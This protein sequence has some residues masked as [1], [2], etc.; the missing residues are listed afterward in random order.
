MNRFTAGN[1]RDAAAQRRRVLSRADSTRSRAPSARSGSRRTSSPT[2]RPGARSPMRWSRAAQRGVSVRVLVD[3]WG[4]RHYLTRPL[5]QRLVDGGVDLLKYRP[6][7]HAVAFPL[8]PAAPAASQAVP[9]RRARR[10]RRRHQRH[11]RHEHAGPHAAARRLRRARARSDARADHPDDAARVGDRRDRAAAQLRR[12]AVSRRGARGERR[13][14][15]RRSSR[16]ATTCAIGATSSAPISPAM[17][18]ARREILIATA[19]FFPGRALSP[20]ADQRGRA[21]RARD[22]AAAGARRVPAAALCVAR[23]VRPAAD[24]R[25]RDPGISSLVPAREGRRRRLAAGRPSA[26]RTSIRTRS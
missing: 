2:T 21:R 16:F 20:R 12:A 3:G 24:G 11:R 26:R 7:V 15:G 4:A 17:R 22:A 18:T 6:E 19:Y 14:A 23:A 13:H 1:S 10:V 5:E 25:R 9:R 8:A